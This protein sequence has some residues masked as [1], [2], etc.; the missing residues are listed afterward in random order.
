MN[1]LQLETIPIC[2][3]DVFDWVDSTILDHLQVVAKIRTDYLH[4]SESFGESNYTPHDYTD[5][6]MA[7][8][9]LAL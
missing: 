6:F 4:P 7:A 1:C 2:R 9:S 5:A 3:L 8:T